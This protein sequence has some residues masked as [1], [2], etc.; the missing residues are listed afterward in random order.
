MPI[1]LQCFL[2][3]MLGWLCEGQRIMATERSDKSLKGIDPAAQLA[4]ENA[5]L[6]SLLDECE[7]R[8]ASL[9]WVLG[10]IRRGVEWQEDS[11]ILRLIERSMEHEEDR[12]Q[13]LG[14]NVTRMSIRRA[15]PAPV[16][17]RDLDSA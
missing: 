16:V 5:R 8:I 12:G 4:A 6:S 11:P 9:M 14:P 2:G 13:T 1:R 15:P 7:Q 10:V 3:W 17:C